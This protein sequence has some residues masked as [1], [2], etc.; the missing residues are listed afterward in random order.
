[1]LLNV[2]HK[3]TMK[4]KNSYHTLIQLFTLIFI[5]FILSQNCLALSS[6]KDKPIELEADSADINDK[7]GISI[8]RGNVILIQGSTQLHAETLTLFHNQQ[9]KLTKLEAIGSPARFKQRPDKQK[10]DVKAKAGKIIYYVKKELIHLY[11]NASFWQGKNSFQGEEIIYD[12]KN[13]IVK[14]TSKKTAD[15]KIQS[16]G[17]VKVIIQSQ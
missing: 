10:D 17:R 9:H 6:D 3:S 1:M 2:P 12:T 16:G 14:A 8:Y 13:D 4:Y 7:K 5:N 11:N 15:G